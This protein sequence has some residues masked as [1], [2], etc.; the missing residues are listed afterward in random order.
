MFYRFY[1][2]NTDEIDYDRIDREN[3]ED[4]TKHGCHDTHAFIVTS[5]LF[6][7]DVLLGVSK[8][9]LAQ[10]PVPEEKL[11][12]MPFG[13]YL[14][15]TPMWGE[16]Y[17]IGDNETNHYMYYFVAPEQIPAIKAQLYLFRKKTSVTVTEL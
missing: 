5:K 9:F 2:R 7:G 12:N 14:D 10:F 3:F 1:V 16:D 15:G 6:C 11:C 8:A 4:S 17:G 13:V